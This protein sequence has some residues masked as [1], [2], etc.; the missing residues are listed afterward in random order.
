MISE[1]RPGTGISASKIYQ[2]IG[3]KAKI[4]ISDGKMI[5]FKDII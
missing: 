1:R 5:K 4:N 2:V 3:K